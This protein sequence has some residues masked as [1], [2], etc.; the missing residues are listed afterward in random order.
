M[1]ESQAQ[2]QTFARSLTVAE[3]R[4]LW[5]HVFKYAGVGGVSAQEQFKKIISYALNFLTGDAAIEQ[6]IYAKAVKMLEDL[7]TYTL[8]VPA[9][10]AQIVALAAQIA[11]EVPDQSRRVQLRFGTCVLLSP[12]DEADTVTATYALATLNNAL[13]PETETGAAA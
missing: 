6:R 11:R 2:R 5:G 8:P 3:K 10:P 1:P 13:Q 12:D 7:R 4:Y 9:T